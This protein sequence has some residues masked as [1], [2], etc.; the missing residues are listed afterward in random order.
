MKTLL[1]TINALSA[2]SIPHGVTSLLWRCDDVNTFTFTE[3]LVAYASATGAVTL[4]RKDVLGA[5]ASGIILHSMIAHTGG[6]S[7][8]D[9]RG[10]QTSL[11]LHLEPRRHRLAT[12]WPRGA[13]HLPRREVAPFWVSSTRET[14][15]LS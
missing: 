11:I 13:V 6:T 14:L 5:T 10:D 12:S 15:E 1:N 4:A 2:E 9:C 7:F 8:D 3:S